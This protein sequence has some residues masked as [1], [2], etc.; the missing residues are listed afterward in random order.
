MSTKTPYRKLFS[1]ASRLTGLFPETGA[2]FLDA[3][4]TLLLGNDLLI[5]SRHDKNAGQIARVKEFR[6]I[7]VIGD[8]NIGDAVTLQAAISALRDFF[9][10][11]EIDYCVNRFARTLVEGNHEISRLWPIF[12][13]TYVPDKNDFCR[14]KEIV[15]WNNYDLI[16]NFCPLFKEDRLASSGV[17]IGY[18]ELAAMLIR[19]RDRQDTVNHI[20]YKT[21]RFVHELLSQF[22]APQ[23]R[24]PFAGVT[25]TL[26]DN[27]IHR[28]QE[29]L[30]CSELPAGPLV[31]YNPDA[32]SAL[33]RIPFE[34]Q[35]Y[36]LKKILA[37][38]STILIGAG[39]TAKDIGLRLAGLLSQGAGR[40]VVVPSSLPLD[41]YAA[42]I[43]HCAAF[44]SADTGPLHVAAARKVS[45]S[46]GHIFRNRTSVFS[47]F[48]ATPARMYGYDSCRPGFFP[49]HQDAPSYSYASASR[50]R[51]ITCVNKMAK[52]CASVR[53][54]ESLD[55]DLI[56]NDLQHRIAGVMTAYP[57]YHA[58]V[59][60][61]VVNN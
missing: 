51:N 23:R 1:F 3:V 24:R 44:I 12:T 9:P 36:L 55:L 57:S 2:L 5:R 47:I 35:L 30:A 50:C 58:A 16:M 8:F 31:F 60:T 33:T 37:T 49:A 10:E 34:Q 54:F 29:F 21:H 48:G 15:T 18:S 22:R 26:S 59:D 17:A 14:L 25:V 19:D 40:I 27:A 46:G 4:V 56:A 11:A 41:A 39:H 13:G 32:S 43:D 45:R 61:L 20:I 28:A 53:C 38:G 42:L 7:L 52:T 6:K